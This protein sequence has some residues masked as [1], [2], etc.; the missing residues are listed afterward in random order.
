M[1]QL[2]VGDWI[3]LYPKSNSAKTRIETN[4]Q[5]WVVEAILE[6]QLKLRSSEKTFG[7][8]K[9]KRYDGMLIWLEHDPNYEWSL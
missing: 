6:T 9:Q 7:S 2:K 1:K 4:G 3:K 5:Y 8:P